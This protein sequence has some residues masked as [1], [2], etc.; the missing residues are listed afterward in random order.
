MPSKDMRH[1]TEYSAQFFVSFFSSN[2]RFH[3]DAVGRGIIG[4]QMIGDKDILPVGYT[5]HRYM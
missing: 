3:Y 1:M 5:A 4:C 2:T